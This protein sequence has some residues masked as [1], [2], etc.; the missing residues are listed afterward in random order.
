MTQELV[1]VTFRPKGEC[2]LRARSP[3]AKGS[4]RLSAL[5]TTVLMVTGC[6]G[7]RVVERRSG[8]STSRGRVV[9]G[10]AYA[11]YARGQYHERNDQLED[12]EY[13]Y[14]Q[15]TAT[16]PGAGTAWGALLRVRCA[17]K[18][19]NVWNTFD[20]AK[21]LAVEQLP[22]LIA[23]SECARQ[24]GKGS[25]AVAWARSA[26]ELDPSSEGASLAL[27]SALR[28]TGD[29]AAARSVVTAFELFQGRPLVPLPLDAEEHRMI[30]LRDARV[31]ADAA[32]IAGDM[33]LARSL[34]VGT[35]DDGELALRAL[36]LGRPE[37]AKVQSERV[38]F[39]DPGNPEAAF[40]LSQLH[41]DS[42][43]LGSLRASSA[44]PATPLLLCA[45]AALVPGRLG[46]EAT[47]LFGSR[48]PCPP[49]TDDPLQT[50][51]SQTLAPKRERAAE[52]RH[53]P[54]SGRTERGFKDERP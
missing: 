53:A 6:A 25:A 42:L 2:A 1:A 49:S 5:L 14:D 9:P 29:E 20:R 32:I 54:K 7:P 44:A 26:V 27:A 39:L 18:K 11:W 21:A 51:L 33:N 22:V 52:G 19:L 43:A 30:S 45:W 8:A 23:A 46:L 15:A 16:D 50:R 47:T 35:L 17:R 48:I 4:A 12:A 41:L 24:T 36:L 37:L 28:S 38:L 40:A 10:E 31:A 13:S 3:H 34:S